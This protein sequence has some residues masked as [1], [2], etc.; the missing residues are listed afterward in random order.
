MAD[1]TRPKLG[2]I[3]SVS[4]EKLIFSG[5]GL[6]RTNRGVVFVDFA[7]PGDELEVEIIEV[8]K[9][10]SRARISKILKPSEKRIS[11]PCKYFSFCGGCDWQH[12]SYPEQLRSKHQLLQELF[13]RELGFSNIEEVRES[14]RQLNYRNRIQVH[15]SSRGPSFRAKR[16]HELVSIDHCLIA[17]DRI[18]EQLVTLKAKVGDRIQLSADSSGGSSGESSAELQTLAEDELSFDFSQVNTG[19]NQKLH[20]QVRDWLKDENPSKFLDLYAGSGNFSFLLAECFPKAS[21]IAVESHPISVQKAQAEIRR[22]KWSSQRLAFLNSTVD[23]VLGR[24]ETDNKTLIFVDP[25]RTGLSPAVAQQLSQ[26]S[27]SR[28]IYLS[29][30]PVTLARDLKIILSR[31]TLALERVIPFDMFPQT[32]HCEVLVSIKNVL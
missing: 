16:S 15:Y 19:Q 27:F 20:A 8:K 13:L 26:M 11:P 29:C 10:F 12:L 30:D 14:S 17:E 25:P 24:L 18:N 2:D 7:A 9:N 4:I 6:A 31:K 21:G 22:R 5:P 23:A 28:L 1:F 32:S 3:L